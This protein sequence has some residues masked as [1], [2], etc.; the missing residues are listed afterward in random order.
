M[1]LYK[2]GDEFRTTQRYLVGNTK[3]YIVLHPRKQ[4]PKEM[5]IGG[6]P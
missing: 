6:F 4:R 5:Y 2:T 3:R 1:V